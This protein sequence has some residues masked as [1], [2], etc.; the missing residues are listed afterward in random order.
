MKVAGDPLR[1]E[2]IRFDPILG[3][4]GGYMCVMMFESAGPAG[5]RPMPTV[6]TRF[7]QIRVLEN[8]TTSEERS[9]Q[10]A[11]L[12]SHESS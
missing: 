7:S 10:T 6:W 1:R 4:A 3:R 11:D 5:R 8:T 9:D 2:I 12:V